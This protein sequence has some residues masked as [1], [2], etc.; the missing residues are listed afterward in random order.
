MYLVKIF[1]INA[2]K[3]VADEYLAKAVNKRFF[4]NIK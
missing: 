4:K 1:T 3:F 2:E